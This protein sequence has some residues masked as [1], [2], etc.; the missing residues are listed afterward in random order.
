MRIKN[1]KCLKATREAIL[2]ESKEEP[3]CGTTWIPQSQILDDSDVWK[4]GDVGIHREQS[5]IHIHINPGGCIEFEGVRITSLRGANLEVVE[6][7]I[8]HGEITITWSDSEVRKGFADWIERLFLPKVQILH[9]REMAIELLDVLA[10]FAPAELIGSFGR[11]KPT[12]EHD[13][14]VLLLNVRPAAKLHLREALR[15]LLN[16]SS[17]EDTDL[18]SWYFHDT[19]YG[20]VDVFFERPT[21][22]QEKS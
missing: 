1:V 19:I 13:I 14:D 15:K 12:S 20:N 2:V 10:L 16:A 22:T 5:M 18:G 17:V 11:G 7:V 6:G 21:E 8:T 9:T 4:E 3:I